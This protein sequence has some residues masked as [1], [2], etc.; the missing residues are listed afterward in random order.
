MATTGRPAGGQRDH[1]RAPE[2]RRWWVLASA[3][4][5]VIVALAAAFAL[6]RGDADPSTASVT[7]TTVPATATAPPGEPCPA[8]DWSLRDRLGQLVMVGVDPTGPA[9]AR[10]V[11]EQHHIGGVFVGGSATGLLTS[12]VLRDL[13]GADG[14]APFVAVDDEGGRVQRID[15]LDGDLPSARVLGGT[16]S[17]ADVTELAEARGRALAGY[18]VTI[19]FAPSIDVSDQADGEVIGDRSFGADAAT[20]I[21]NARA[22]AEGLEAAGIVPVFKHFPGHG[23]AVG[24]SHEGTSTAPALDDLDPDLAPFRTLLD[25]PGTHAVMVGHLVVPGLTDGE[26]ASLSAPAIDGLLRDELGYDGLVF[27]DELGGMRAVADRYGPAEAVQ[28]ALV[29]GADVALLAD[30]TGVEELLDQLEQAVADG[31]LPTSVVDTAFG[32]V[33]TAKGYACGPRSVASRLPP[34]LTGR[35]RRPTASERR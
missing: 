11:V 30:G 5:V 19:D 4:G 7:S 32:R 12:G 17:L 14:V 26:P 28:R 10:E 33:L 1:S 9:E 29:A 27:T 20:V 23:H 25:E 15:D 24:D 35:A 18:G 6:D 13:R 8:A 31:S 2:S 3:I 16:R 34:D 21:R 22:F